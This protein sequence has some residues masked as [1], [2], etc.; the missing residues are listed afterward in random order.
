MSTVLINRKWSISATRSYLACPRQWWLTRVANVERTVSED[1]FQGQL[2][3][4][5]LA[6]GYA[7]MGRAWAEGRN[8]QVVQR[9]G[10]VACEFGIAKEA[11]RLAI[12]YEDG[13]VD[14]A[15]RALMHLGP[16][17]DDQVVGVERDMDLRVD[18]VPIGYRADV[19]YRRGGVL[20]VRDWKSRKSLPKARDLP[21]DWQLALGAL[22]VAR[23]YGE[24]VVR[25]ELA[26]IN[27]ATSVAFPITAQAA[28][29]A[30][31]IVAETARTAEADTECLPLPG[32][33]CNDCK[34]VAHCTVYAKPNTVI[35]TPFPD[36]S[37]ASTA[38]ID[39]EV[40]A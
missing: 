20:V 10:E 2:M 24:T 25:V 15:V 35:L 29:A 5:G 39:I 27:G 11:D 26:S 33:A 40:D 17:Q 30:G 7:E 22:A 19:V 1:S 21:R 28:Q 4:A 31:R 23:T 16:R 12:D 32:A 13:L 9:R 36:G 34:V 37:P 3:H 14:T 38:V 6:A 18:G 8:L